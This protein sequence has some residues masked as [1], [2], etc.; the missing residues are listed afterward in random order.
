M[1]VGIVGQRGNPRAA[2]LVEQLR[3]ALPDDVEAV[4]DESTAETID[5]DGVPPA[6]MGDCDL[7][8]SVGGD[9]TF[10]FSARSV[11]PTPVLGVNLG[12]VGFLN[13]VSPAEAIDIVR[14]SV[15]ELRAGQL[16]T[17]EVSRLRASGDDWTLA[18]AINEIVVHGPRR[19]PGDGAGFEVRIDGALYTGGQADGVLVAT[20]T[21]STAYNLSEGGPLLHP[22]VDGMVVTEMCAAEELRPLVVDPQTTVQVRIDEADH[23]YVIGDGRDRTRLDVPEVIEIG[24]ADEPLRIAGPELSFFEALG[25]LE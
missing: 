3:V 2:Q 13:A 1:R 5:V 24:I 25:K 11:A 20:P 14:E 8:V 21:G 17:R 12:E 18:P 15:A 10:I 7:V 6:T 4:V 19:G 23:G 16:S 22:T 9:G